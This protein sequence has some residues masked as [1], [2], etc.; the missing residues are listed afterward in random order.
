MAGED[1]AG[2]GMVRQGDVLLVPVE[3]ERDQGTV[4]ARGRLVLAEGE[5]TGHAHVV[6]SPRAQLRSFGARRILVVS[7]RRRVQLV[8]EEH[9]PVPVE[10][11]VWEVVR[12]RE[13]RPNTPV[14]WS[15]VAD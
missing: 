10:P 1:V 3:L 14:R 8:H 5:A 2:R 4:V 11:G 15:R 12:Q 7:G 13:Y 6:A 9:D